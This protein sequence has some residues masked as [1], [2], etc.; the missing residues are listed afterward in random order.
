M[1]LVPLQEPEAAVEELR[2]VVTELGM[3]GAMLPSTGIQAQLGDRRYWPIYEEANR[4]GC[5]LG[6][7]GGAHEN[8]GMDDLTP[9]APVHALGHP[10]GQMISFGAL[11][12][13]GI[14]DRFP[15]AKIGF[16]EGGVAW[17][18]M[19][20]ERFDRSWETHIQRDPRKRFLELRPKEKVSEYIARQID[21]G[22]VFIG[23]EGEEPDIA[24]AVKRVGN[25]PW[26]FSSDYPHEVN[27]EF[28]KH[29]ISEMLENEGL[30][31]ADKAAILHGNARRF[32]SLGAA[33]L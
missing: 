10:F 5:A 33:G 23:C 25:K 6:I 29:E 11:V 28:C 18:L 22:R 16:M 26:V 1:A 20:L 2:R 4:L 17:L 19:C 27:N 15:N 12:F 9:Y 32:Y 3:C 7:H 8:L 13:N 24:Y 31:Q 14:F 21:E 30:T